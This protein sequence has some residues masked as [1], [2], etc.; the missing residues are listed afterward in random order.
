MYTQPIRYPKEESNN[1]VNN[2]VLKFHGV[3]SDIKSVSNYFL[4]YW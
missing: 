1:G 3:V 2:T 4:G